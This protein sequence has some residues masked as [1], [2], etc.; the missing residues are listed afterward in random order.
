MTHMKD[1]LY[2]CNNELVEHKKKNINDNLYDD[3]NKIVGI[4]IGNNIYIKYSNSYRYNGRYFKEDI[5]TN[6]VSQILNSEMEHYNLKFKKLNMH[7]N[8]NLG[9][10][11]EKF[12]ID[13]KEI[14]NIR[15]QD[16]YITNESNSSNILYTG[17]KYDDS[18]IHNLNY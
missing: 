13:N 18:S 17:I 8:E 1:I 16:F 9:Y 4:V 7:D 11:A 3:V 10:I 15:R 5:V 2:K 12:N 6:N 14:P